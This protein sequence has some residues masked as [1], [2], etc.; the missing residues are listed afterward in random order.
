M[1]SGCYVVTE[2]AREAGQGN[3]PRC[4]LLE[5]AFSIAGATAFFRGN[6]GETTR[7]ILAA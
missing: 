3:S 7:G 5:N 1:L 2:T 4:Y 6:K